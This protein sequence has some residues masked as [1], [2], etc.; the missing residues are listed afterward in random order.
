VRSND[1]NQRA[2]AVDPDFPFSF[3][4]AWLALTATATWMRF[5]PEHSVHDEGTHHGAP[6]WMTPT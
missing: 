6:V 1:G 2:R 4:G 5:S 3:S